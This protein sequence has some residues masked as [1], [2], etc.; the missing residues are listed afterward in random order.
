MAIPV[1]IYGKSGAGKSRSLK[2]FA[3][4]EIYLVNVLGK[5]LPF[6][7]SFKYVTTGD[8]LQKIMA[9]LSKMGGSGVK[10]AVVDDFG[11]IMTNMFMRG[12][13]AGDQFRL[14]NQIGDTVWSFINFIKGPAVAPDAI[15]YLI[16]HEDLNE[17]GTNKLRTIGKLLDQKVCIEGMVTVAL[18]AVNKGDTYVFETQ[19]KGSGIAKSPEGMFSDVEIPNDL[20]AVDTAIREYWSL[21]SGEASRE[22]V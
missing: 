6:R 1:L 8:D 10:T 11:Y 2:G 22:E 17:D 14:Y 18:H 9:K 13:G 5:Q 12:H 7:G 3:E 20:K 4:D 21:G 19:S 15:V 16:M